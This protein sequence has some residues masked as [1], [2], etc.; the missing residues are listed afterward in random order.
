MSRSR[1][2]VKAILTDI[3]GTTSALSF[4]KDTLFP[5]ARAH[6]ADYIYD[7]ADEIENLIEDIKK[8][9]RNSGLNLE[10]IIEVLL[11]YIDEDQKITPLKTL[12]GLI[13]EEGYKTGELTGH[14][15]DDAVHGLTRWNEQ[16]IDLYVYSSGS[17]AAQK[18]LF[19]NTEYG[20]LTPLFKGYF[21]TTTGHKKDPESYEKI[22]AQIAIDPASILFL[23]D[24]TEEIAAAH[25]AGMQVII[26]DR[27][28]SLFDA[29]EHTVL[30]D[31]NNILDMADA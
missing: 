26:L 27:E 18:L 9:E 25:K 22:A 16:G 20:D 11:R 19:A 28:K 29:G 5:Y 6:L 15:Y 8:E 12:Q 3:E 23:S 2:T 1:K 31:F 30:F 14:V 4:V 21:D 24:S 17:I 10:E 7:Y 13:W